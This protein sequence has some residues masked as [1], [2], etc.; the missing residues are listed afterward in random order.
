MKEEQNILL[1]TLK[2]KEKIINNLRNTLNMI[3]K[4]KEK[5]YKFWWR[6]RK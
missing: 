3:T 1:I 6:T 5:N 2:S 4:E